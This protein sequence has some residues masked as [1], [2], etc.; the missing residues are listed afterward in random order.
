MH[1]S[2]RISRALL[3]AAAVAVMAVPGTAQ[4]APAPATPAAPPTMGSVVIQS[5]GNRLC[6]QP[7]SANL[8]VPVVQERCQPGLDLQRWLFQ[9]L[10]S[11]PTYRFVNARSGGC[12]WAFEPD[13]G[14]LVGV[15]RCGDSPFSNTE[16]NS[17]LNL[18]DSVFLESLIGFGHTGECLTVPP[19]GEDG[20]EGVQMQV[21]LCK[22]AK[23]SVAGWNI[24]PNAQ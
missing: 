22:N 12:L 6:L 24:L 4:A 16:F 20:T 2:T 10:G 8:D 3:G 5:L 11:G 15:E 9:K 23:V 17:G 7:T 14:S 19:E 18:P 13:G 21:G 1:I